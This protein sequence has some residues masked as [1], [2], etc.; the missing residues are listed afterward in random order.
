MVASMFF[1]AYKQLFKW[2]LVLSIFF[3]ATFPTQGKQYII[4]K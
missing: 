3:G 4:Q 1:V 2:M